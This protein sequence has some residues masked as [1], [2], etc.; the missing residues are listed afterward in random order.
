[1]EYLVG[2]TLR[3]FIAVG[4]GVVPGQARS[5]PGAAPKRGARDLRFGIRDSRSGIRDSEFWILDSRLGHPGPETRF[6]V[7]GRVPQ[8]S[9]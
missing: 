7:P 4:K 9:F 2:Q 1:M 8:P 3:E 6:R 5:N